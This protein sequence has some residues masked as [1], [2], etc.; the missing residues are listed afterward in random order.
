MFSGYDITLDQ[1][2]EWRF[3]DILL[4]MMSF[5]VLI[6]VHQFILITVRIVS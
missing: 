4:E 5:L 2:G 1:P 6:I 3:D